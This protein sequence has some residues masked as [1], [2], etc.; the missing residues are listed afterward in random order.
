MSKNKY[1]ISNRQFFCT[2]FIV[3]LNSNIKIPL[4]TQR[5]RQREEQR[6]ERSCRRAA[7]DVPHRRQQLYRGESLGVLA[8]VLCQ[9]GTRLQEHRQT[10]QR[11]FLQGI[12]HIPELSSGDTVDDIHHQLD[13][14]P[15]EGLPARHEDAWGNAQRGIRNSAH[16]KD[17]HG[18]TGIL[19]TRARN[20]VRQETLPRKIKKSSA[21][22]PAEE[23]TDKLIYLHY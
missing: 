17:G 16:G 10:W 21:G 7:A 5:H 3:R 12:F 18:Q 13:R 22:A 19:Q 15:A 14:A 23:I 20:R 9:M 6:Q 2:F 8:A 11:P 4:Q 1:N